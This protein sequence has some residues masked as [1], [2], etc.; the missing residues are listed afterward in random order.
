[1][2]VSSW[3]YHSWKYRLAW[4]PDGKESVAMPFD[5]YCDWVQTGFAREG[6][7]Q[8][9][10]CE[11]N[12]DMRADVQTALVNSACQS[13]TTCS[14]LQNLAGN[15]IIR[16][17]VQRETLAHRPLDDRRAAESYLAAW[18]I[19]ETRV[20]DR[21]SLEKPEQLDLY[22]SLL[23]QVATK[24]LVE[25]KIDERGFFRVA[26][27]DVVT[28]RHDGRSQSFSVRRVLERSGLV[29]ADP[30]AAGAARYSIEPFWMHR[31]LVE[32]HAERVTERPRI[33]LGSSAN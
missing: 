1:L 17:I 33:L 2:A 9:I 15:A 21:P 29:Y 32:M 3:N 19:R 12:E 4:A 16:E 8:S 14:D 25:G 24:Y 27:D 11:G 30:C 13:R 7:F 28:V 26:D 31:L 5:A 23:G 20:H 10:T 22:V 18:L 6:R